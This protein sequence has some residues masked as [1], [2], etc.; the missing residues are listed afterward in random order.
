MPIGEN[1]TNQRV[2]KGLNKFDLSKSSGVAPVRIKKIEEGEGYPNYK[3]LVN[4]CNAL[5][6]S[7]NKLVDLNEEL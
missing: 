2:K 3:S 4:L 5:E 7:P 1:L 6:C